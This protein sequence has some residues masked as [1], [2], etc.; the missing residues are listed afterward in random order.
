MPSKLFIVFLQNIIM[1]IKY[2]VPDSCIF[3]ESRLIY[4]RTIL[5]LFELFLCIMTFQKSTIMLSLR[6]INYMV[7][8]LK[9]ILNI[10]P[11]KRK[12]TFCV[13]QIVFWFL[14]NDRKT[15]IQQADKDNTF[16]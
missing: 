13:I 6:Q 12:Y 11:I 8:L 4:E 15:H 10:L 3:L 16:I 5:K 2:I 14:F 9:C 7:C 1:Q